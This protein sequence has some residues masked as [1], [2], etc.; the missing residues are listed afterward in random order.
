MAPEARTRLTPDSRRRQIL[1]VARRLYATHPYAAVTTAEVAH[2]AGVTRGLVHHY[3]GGVRDLYITVLE[4]VAAEAIAI[5]GSIEGL[6]REQRVARN[7]DAWLDL[8]ESNRETFF[9]LAMHGGAIPD[10]VI[11]KLVDAGRDAATDRIVEANSDLISDTPGAR[12]A[13]RGL[14]AMHEAACAQWLSGKVSRDQVHTLL[15][16]VFLDLLTRTIP[17]LEGTVEAVSSGS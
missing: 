2:E 9:A 8:T 3:F 7:I 1:D 15:T 16:S 14:L 12:L 4:E 10:P 6:S 17:Q 5:P 11:R 13:L